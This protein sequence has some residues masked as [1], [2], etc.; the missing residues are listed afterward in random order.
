MT[1]TTSSEC[2]RRFSRHSLLP[3]SSSTGSRARRKWKRSDC[4][5]KHRCVCD[6]TLP[7]EASFC[8]C[9]FVADAVRTREAGEQTEQRA[10]EERQERLRC[11]DTIHNSTTEYIRYMHALQHIAMFLPQAS[12]TT[13]SQHCVQATCLV[14]T[15]SSC[16][17]CANATTT[18]T[19]TAVT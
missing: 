14:T 4:R 13:S 5:R 2:S 15:S 16:D 10:Q 8:S 18:T 3:D 17:A 6:V 11:V 9:L 1:Q 19:T 7:V 12:S